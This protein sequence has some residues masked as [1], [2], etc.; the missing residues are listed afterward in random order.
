MFKFPT[1]INFLLVNPNA[2]L[3]MDELNE[4][5]TAIVTSLRCDLIASK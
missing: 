4:S 5:V 1:K 2:F 3:R